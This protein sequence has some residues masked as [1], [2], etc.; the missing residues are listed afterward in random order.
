MSSISHNSQAIARVNSAIVILIDE[1][2]VRH[3]L[4]KVCSD[5]AQIFR[6][7]ATVEI[8]VAV[9]VRV[10][11]DRADPARLARDTG[12]DRIRSTIGRTPTEGAYQSIGPRVA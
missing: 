4:A 3:W 6:V 9:K 12:E 5:Q 10:G 7:D 11:C 2:V 1:H 8:D